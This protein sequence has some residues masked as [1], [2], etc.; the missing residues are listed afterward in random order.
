MPSERPLLTDPRLDPFRDLKQRGGQRGGTFVAEGE[1]LVV[2]LLASG[3]EVDTIACTPAL[4]VRLARQISDATN[5]LLLDSHE[6]SQ[7][8]GFQFHRGVLALGRIP[9]APSLTGLLQR[10]PLG[11]PALAIGCPELRDP[12]NLGTI[13][14]TALALGANM[15]LVGTEGVD[16]W[17]RRV[18]RTSM[19][20]IF[21]LPV[22]ETNDWPEVFRQL[23]Q[24]KFETIATV[25][26][27]AAESLREARFAHRRA[28]FLGTEDPGLSD[29]IA[30]SCRRR[31][32]LPM[33]HGVDSLNVA[34]AAGIV[35]YQATADWPASGPA[36]SQE[37]S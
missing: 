29:E 19:G 25:L 12:T 33:A 26:D 15:L 35:M 11:E 6:I 13:A 24:E 27:A 20:A 18:L 10:L 5:V 16:P 30:R 37:A 31:V 23:H 21:Q 36:T 3:L 7:L 8:I 2:R 32:T 22:I 4:H 17:S 28:V 14:R 9:P 34:V 1:K